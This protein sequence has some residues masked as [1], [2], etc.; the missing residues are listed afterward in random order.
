MTARINS[1]RYM[2][3]KARAVVSQWLSISGILHCPHSASCSTRFRITNCLQTRLH[4][5]NKLD[6]SCPG[7]ASS[8]RK[9]LLRIWFFIFLL[10]FT[11]GHSP[12]T[13]RHWGPVPFP[14]H[15]IPTRR[16]CSRGTG[17]ACSIQCFITK[18]EPVKPADTTFFV[19]WRQTNVCVHTYTC[20]YFPAVGHR[21]CQNP[22]SSLP[23]YK[24]SLKAQNHEVTQGP[25]PPK[26]SYSNSFPMTGDFPMGLTLSNFSAFVH[27]ALG[28]TIPYCLQCRK[29]PEHCVA[30]CTKG[31]VGY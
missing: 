31:T 29:N 24:Q 19:A 21:G 16:D 15:Q 14:K 17:D 1:P 23:V 20:V 8:A 18:F 22:S 6:S 10:H 2:R 30:F 9:V 5:F 4:S 13:K 28:N 3:A 25:L 11:L 26:V 12:L 27:L 7:L